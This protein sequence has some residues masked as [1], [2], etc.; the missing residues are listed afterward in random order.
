M[1]NN[2]LIW[3]ELF[4]ELDYLS[5]LALN[6]AYPSRSWGRVVFFVLFFAVFLPIVLL[7][8]LCTYSGNEEKKSDGGGPLVV[9]YLLLLAQFLA[10][11]EKTVSFALCTLVTLVVSP[12]CLSL[13]LGI[14]SS[15]GKSLRSDPTHK[16]L[17]DHTHQGGKEFETFPSSSKYY[18]TKFT[19]S[20]DRVLFP[21]F[22]TGVVIDL[23]FPCD[24]LHAVV[25]WG[26]IKTLNFYHHSKLT[27]ILPDSGNHS[28]L[29]KK[30]K[31]LDAELVRGECQNLRQFVAIDKI[32]ETL[33]SSCRLSVCIFIY[34]L[35]IRRLG[36]WLISFPVFTHL[37]G[38]IGVLLGQILQTGI[39]SL[40]PV[41]SDKDEI[42]VELVSVPE[43]YSSPKTRR[44]PDFLYPLK[45]KG[46]SVR[47]RP[48]V[49]SK[50]KYYH[51]GS[52]DSRSPVE[53]PLLADED[54]EL[55]LKHFTS[56]GRVTF[57]QDC[58]YINS[59]RGTT[60]LRRGSVDFRQRCDSGDSKRSRTIDLARIDVDRDVS[61]GTSIDS[62]DVDVDVDLDDGVL[63]NLGI[64][65]QSPT[66]L[67]NIMRRTSLPA[68]LPAQRHS[69]LHQ[70]W[71]YI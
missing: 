63:S 5:N 11:I 50:Q 23:C 8:L 18:W 47:D 26:V 32:E 20:P 16:N 21:L 15:T 6:Q 39:G 30:D 67:R 22:W 34:F 41:G 14:E 33:L 69:S 65:Y 58:E 42:R 25:L 7:L 28:A 37:L 38:I 64:V 40:N 56:G 57:G 48:L 66:A 35:L 55:V 60:S 9:F 27:S 61:I 13:Y 51:L 59:C 70:V 54:G 49:V 24:I 4:Y 53:T 19:P 71:D 17:R 44:N 68:A 52:I 12:A 2:E 29:Q 10:E 43:S 46:Q 45:S 1:T 3:R 36:S 62:V 31:D